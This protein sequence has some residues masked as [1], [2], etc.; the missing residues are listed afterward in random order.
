MIIKMPKS[1]K[2]DRIRLILDC[3]DPCR[4]RNKAGPKFYNIEA[5]VLA[6]GIRKNSKVESVAKKIKE[7]IDEKLGLEGCDYTVDDDNARR[8]AEAILNSVITSQ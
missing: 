1:T 4:M 8:F 3:W 7:V 2:V 5:E 6:Q